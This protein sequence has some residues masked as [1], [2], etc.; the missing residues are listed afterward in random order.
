M[1]SSYISAA[2]ED[3]STKFGLLIDFDFLRA[4]TSTNT[5]PEVVF[6]GR[7][8]HL[9]Y[10]KNVNNSGLDKGICSKFDEKMH[11]DHAEMTHDQKSKPEVNLRDVIRRITH[12]HTHTTLFTF[13][14]GS[15]IIRKKN[16]SEHLTNQQHETLKKITRALN[17]QVFILSLCRTYLFAL[18]SMLLICHTFPTNKL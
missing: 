8:R 18:V 15:T 3:I 9:E 5:K 17:L 10:G 16:E 2:N 6:S 7:G 12:T 13:G 11:H 1:C 4:V 14:K